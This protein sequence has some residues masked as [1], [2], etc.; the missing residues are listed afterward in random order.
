MQAV[1]AIE[2]LNGTELGGRRLLVREDREDRD[3]KGEGDAPAAPRAPR[4][5]RAAAGGRG[6][7]SAG[8]GAGRGRGAG[9]P[10]QGGESSGLQ[11][12]VAE[13]PCKTAWCMCRLN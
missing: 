9:P 2:T 10:A 4:A 7:P 13:G 1:A 8:R 3:L 6:A 11:V 12:G 5:P